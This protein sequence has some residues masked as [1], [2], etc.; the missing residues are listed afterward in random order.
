MRLDKLSKA[1]FC[2]FGENLLL[3]NQSEENRNT[4]QKS[5]FLSSKTTVKFNKTKAQISLFSYFV[6]NLDNLG[7]RPLSYEYMQV[8]MQNNF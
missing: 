2:K 4:K 6:N 8:K 5:T 3:R 1:F 7:G